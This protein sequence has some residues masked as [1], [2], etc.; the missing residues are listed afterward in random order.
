MLCRANDTSLCFVLF[1]NLKVTAIQDILSNALLLRVIAGVDAIDDRQSVGTP[2]SSQV[3]DYPGLLLAARKAQSLLLLP[4]ESPQ[5]SKPF[6]VDGINTLCGVGTERGQIS[7]SHVQGALNQ[8]M[9]KMRIGILK[10]G[11]EVKGM[12]PR[13][14]QC[15]QAA[16][17]KFKDLNAEVIEISI[18]EHLTAA[19]IAG[20]HRFTFPQY[21]PGN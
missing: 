18:P 2:C 8:G 6:I 14:F 15:V 12:D 19:M 10:E 11:G 7:E 16:A 17:M 3:P 4:H 5:Q 1:H 21:L 13:V 9:R 20:V